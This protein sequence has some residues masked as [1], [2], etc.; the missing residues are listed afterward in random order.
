MPVEDEEE[1][2]AGYQSAKPKPTKKG[3]AKA[4]P[5]E[6]S[7]P[8]P[9]EPKTTTRKTTKGTTRRGRKV[10]EGDD[11]YDADQVARDTKIAGD[12]PLFS[13]C[14][15]RSISPLCLSSC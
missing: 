11:A 15:V 10:K 4:A 13:A 14:P 1:E 2:E 3:K 7:A 8:K 9:K 12:N 6:K 5:K